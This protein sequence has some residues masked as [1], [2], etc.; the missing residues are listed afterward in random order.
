M[1]NNIKAEN[2]IAE[3]VSHHVFD[4][5]MVSWVCNVNDERIPTSHRKGYDIVF[6]W[7]AHPTK[8][9]KL[10]D[11]ELFDFLRHEVNPRINS[12]GFD[13][14]YSWRIPKYRDSPPFFEV[15]LRLSKE[16]FAKLENMAREYFKDHIESIIRLCQDNATEMNNQPVH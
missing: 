5:V 10:Y 16:D 6:G 9:Y 8:D 13:F 7:R 14:A 4:G 11:I 1:K 3:Y 12:H 2:L 15:T